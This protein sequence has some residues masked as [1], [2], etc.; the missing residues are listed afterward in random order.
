[1]KLKHFLSLEWDAIAGILAAIA[2]I[3]LHSLHIVEVGILL[4]IIPALL[5]LLFISFMRHERSDERMAERVERTESA[6]MNIQSALSPPDV[7]L[8]GPRQLRAESERFN[9]GAHGEM[10]FFNVC[11]LMY[12]P[13]PMFN[14]LLQTAIDNP[15]VTSIL[16]ILDES[17]KNLWESEIMPKIAVCPGRDKVG[18]PRW[19]QLEK[20]ISFILGDTHA[21]GATE[22][23]LSFWGEPFMAHTTKQDVPRYIFRVQ[24][25]SELL[26]RLTELERSYRFHG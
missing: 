9:H 25:H 17:E 1:M 12:K 4:S 19:C 26:A 7:I 8:I 10:V 22:A 5:A 11:L 13:Q 3:I 20:N 18:E 24:K 2:A 23:L 6:V 16:F 21:D 15:R 14:M